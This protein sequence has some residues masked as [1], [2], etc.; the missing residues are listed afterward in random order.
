MTRPLERDWASQLYRLLP[1]VYQIR[2]GQEREVL[3]AYLRVI[4]EQVQELED[5][6]AQLYDNWFVE[7]CS[8]WVVPYL[9]DLLGFR[10]VGNS[11]EPGDALAGG[12]RLLN[13]F[14]FPRR[15]IANLVRRRRRKGT[16]SVLEDVAR[17]VTGWPARAVE[18]SRLV[19]FFQNVNHPQPELGRTLSVRDREELVRINTPFDRVAHTVDVRQMSSRGGVGWYHPRKIGLFVWR[20]VIHSVT[21]VRPCRVCDTVDGCEIQSYTFSRLGQEVPLYINRRSET[22]EFHIA[23]ELNLPVLLYRHLLADPK[24]G[25]GRAGC[26]YY[27]PSTPALPKSVAVWVR[28]ETS[29]E[30]RL[31]PARNVLV[32]D[33]SCGAKRRAAA[34]ELGC[35]QVAIDPECGRLIFPRKQPPGGVQVSYHRAFSHD[36]GGGE[37]DRPATRPAGHTVR[38][39]ATGDFNCGLTSLF[40]ATRDLAGN[41]LSFATEKPS[42]GSPGPTDKHP[43]KWLVRDD[44][45]IELIDSGS[46]QIASSETLEVSAGKTLII[47]AGRGAW[48]FI[49]VCSTG[50]DKCGDPWRVRL[51][52]GS[53]LILEGLLICGATILIEE[54]SRGMAPEAIDGVASADCCSADAHSG[55]V[56]LKPIAAAD[57]ESVGLPF[58]IPSTNFSHSSSRAPA[59]V[60]IRHTTLVPGGRAPGA[61]CSCLPNHASL[62]TQHEYARLCIS[63]SIV[64]T[65]NIQHPTCS[66]HCGLADAPQRTCPLYPLPVTI[67]DSI[68]DFAC[69][70]P[71]IYGNCCAAAH[72]D[73][74]IERSTILGAVQTQQ[75]TRAEDSLFRDFVYVVR[76]ELGYMR[77]CYVPMSIP[78]SAA[79]VHARSLLQLLGFKRDPKQSDARSRTPR[80]FKCL[81]E[82]TRRAP[83]SSCDQG[84]SP[85]NAPADMARSA[86]KTTEPVSEVVPLFVSTR[87]GDP[88]Y[89]QLARDCPVEIRQGAEDESEL[90]AFH[91]LYI[92]QRWAA[93]AARLQEYTPAE[94]ESALIEADDLHPMTFHKLSDG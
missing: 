68:V 92:P 71:S 93:L 42:E 13:R 56:E 46:Y 25:S 20:R 39:S 45:T 60:I 81:P 49:S 26:R 12:G 85:T 78:R 16:L 28:H 88:G 74:T 34:C 10:R 87:Y 52:H 15:E 67:V 1:A 79:V 47:R 4:G 57:G 84:C 21:N 3:A 31:I 27:G 94:M 59:D 5:D 86:G 9:G 8:D 40:A 30:W 18:F 2:D 76:R 82:R 70:L 24:S 83:Q 89:C 62:A 41:R 55:T 44:L 75:M 72:A 50:G 58:A 22:D 23:D 77:F 61:A 33:L 54:P 7:T 17:D 32:R 90:G 65:L 66:A 53:R 69:G 43:A 6:V 38:F 19:T 35:D 37:Y 63:Q 64:G 29:L 80:R 91:D 73:L 11:G 48:P 36:L 51:G 14:L